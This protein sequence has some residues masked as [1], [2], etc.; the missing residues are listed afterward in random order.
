MVTKNTRPGGPAEGA[1]IHV[2]HLSDSGSTLELIKV[3]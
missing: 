3:L 1:H 2:A